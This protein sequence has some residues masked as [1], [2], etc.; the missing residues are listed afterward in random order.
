MPWELLAQRGQEVH[1]VVDTAATPAELAQIIARRAGCP[2]ALADHPW[3]RAAAAWLPDSL[4]NCRHFFG[5]EPLS[6]LAVHTAVLVGLGA[7]PETG[8]VLVSAL[9]PAAWRLTLC[10]RSLVVVVPAAQ[11]DLSMEEALALT[12]QDPSGLVS[13][14]TGPSRTADIEKVLVLGAHGAAALTIILYTDAAS[15]PDPP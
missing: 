6:P 14:L 13:W 5:Q 1:T 7:V 2:L 8:S 3:L 15:P 10:P 12:A 9:L 11:A 4:L